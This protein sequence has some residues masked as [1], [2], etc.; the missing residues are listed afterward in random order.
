MV[1]FIYLFIIAV[2]E[3]SV[4][5]YIFIFTLKFYVVFHG[6]NVFMFSWY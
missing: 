2:L 6:T 1:E 5:H 3:H 4:L